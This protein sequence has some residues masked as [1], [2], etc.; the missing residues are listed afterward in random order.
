MDIEFTL[1]LKIKFCIEIINTM[2]FNNY[3]K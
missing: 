3:L 1:L 2:L